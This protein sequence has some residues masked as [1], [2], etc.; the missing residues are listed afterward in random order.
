[1]Q[2]IIESGEVGQGEQVTSGMNGRSKMASITAILSS[3]LSV[4]DLVSFCIFAVT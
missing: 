2:S 3:V 1:M 4:Y